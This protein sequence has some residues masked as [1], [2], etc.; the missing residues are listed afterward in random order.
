MGKNIKVARCKFKN[1]AQELIKIKI[2]LS[3]VES[4]FGGISR[5]HKFGKVTID[6]DKIRGNE[7]HRA[8]MIT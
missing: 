4:N 8:R 7:V 6:T 5:V 2:E 1:C 3:H